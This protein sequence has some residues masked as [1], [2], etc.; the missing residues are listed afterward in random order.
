M[1]RSRVSANLKYGDHEDWLGA[2]RSTRP[3]GWRTPT[4]EDPGH[5]A[6]RQKD[7]DDT[8]LEQRSSTRRRKDTEPE[9]DRQSNMFP[10]N[11]PPPTEIE[12]AKHL[13]LKQRI[14]HVTWAWFT[15]CMATGG[16]ASVLYSGR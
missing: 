8:L 10:I 3:D 13:T 9:L 6:N 11:P 14:K 15:L 12:K 7:S 4:I 16:I 2:S 1:S 5:P